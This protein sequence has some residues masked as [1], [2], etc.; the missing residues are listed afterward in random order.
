MIKQIPWGKEAETGL[1]KS[2][3]SDLELIKNQVIE[4]QAQLWQINTKETNGYLVTRI[5]VE[6][7]GKVFVFVLGEGRGIV[8]VIP[9]FLESAKKLGIKHFRTHVQRKGLI[10]MWQKFGLEI[11][12]YV[13][14]NDT[15]G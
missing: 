2:A 3:G 1:L 4:N 8:E 11:D 15:N 9:S 7:I 12:H 10:K 13:L 14:R 6:G 5:D